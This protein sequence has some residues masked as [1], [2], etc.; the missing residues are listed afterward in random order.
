MSKI[1]YKIHKGDECSQYD[2][3]R[4]NSLANIVLNPLKTV[5]LL[6]IKHEFIIK[7]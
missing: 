4:L 5:S 6:M 7:I 2:N 3:E 1:G